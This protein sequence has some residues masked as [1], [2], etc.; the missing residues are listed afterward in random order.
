MMLCGKFLG[1]TTQ[2]LYGVALDWKRHCMQCF[3]NPYKN[4]SVSFNDFLP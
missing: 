2:S 3:P 1:N 4:L